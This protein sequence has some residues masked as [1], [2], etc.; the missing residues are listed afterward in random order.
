MRDRRVGRKL[1]REIGPRRALL[2]SLMRAVVLK[3]AVV[4][5]EAKA[6]AVRPVLERVVT[7]ARKDNLEGIRLAASVLGKD[8]ASHLKKNILPAIKER[9]GGYLR[10]TKFGVRRSDSARMA[11][12]SFVD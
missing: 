5:T 9:N 8:A 1:K 3:R 7:R 2:R 11:R 4:T 6:K 12:I 10:I